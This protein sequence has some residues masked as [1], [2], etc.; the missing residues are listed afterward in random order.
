MEHCCSQPL[1]WAWKYEFVVFIYDYRKS[2]FG[3]V[4]C[5]GLTAAWWWLACCSCKNPRY[6][7]RSFPPLHPTPDDSYPAESKQIDEL[8]KYVV[9]RTCLSSLPSFCLHAFQFFLSVYVV[10][11]SFSVSLIVPS[12]TGIPLLPALIPNSL[13]P[14]NHNRPRHL[15]PIIL[16]SPLLAIGFY[17][18]FR[19]LLRAPPISF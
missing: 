16:S 15:H 8:P 2:K 4:C 18:L 19:L 10:H 1:F 11:T 9:C 12:Q 13:Q 5:R 6:R 17:S 7:P 14:E 3:T